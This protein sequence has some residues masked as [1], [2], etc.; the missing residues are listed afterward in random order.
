[1]MLPGRQRD[2]APNRKRNEVMAILI[3]I[4]RDETST[5]PLMGDL[6][7]CLRWW[8]IVHSTNAATT[9]P[10]VNK[11]SWRSR[12]GD[13]LCSRFSLAPWA[14]A[15]SWRRCSQASS[16]FGVMSSRCITNVLQSQFAVEGAGEISTFAVDCD[17]PEKCPVWH[18]VAPCNVHMY[19]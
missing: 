3:S 16:L 12:L 7:V 13:S 18:L 15:N 14:V 8:F 17:P 4:D 1:M 10:R 19:Q 5:L 9:G 2:M 6:N 11:S